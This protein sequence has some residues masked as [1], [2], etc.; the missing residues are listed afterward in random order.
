M[1]T[2]H[3]SVH[4]NQSHMIYWG[5]VKDKAEECVEHILEGGDT[6]T[7]LADIL[8]KEHIDSPEDWDDLMDF[9]KEEGACNRDLNEL[10]RA[11]VSWIQAHNELE[12]KRLYP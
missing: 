2:E 4:S 3:P 11:S 12:Y 6:P 8:D 1:T 7:T 10:Y 9:C 5:R